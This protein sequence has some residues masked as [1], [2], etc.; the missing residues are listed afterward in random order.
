MGQLVASFVA[1]GS[2]AVSCLC[3]VDHVWG[4]WRREEERT[5]AP[6]P[7]PL[8][9][10]RRHGGGPLPSP[11][12]L[13]APGWGMLACAVLSMCINKPPWPESLAS[14]WALGGPVGALQDRRG[15][16]LAGPHGTGQLE[17]SPNLAAGSGA[18][19]AEPRLQRGRDFGGH[20]EL[21]HT[22]QKGKWR[23]LR[24][25]PIAIWRANEGSQ[26]PL[27]GAFPTAASDL[28]AADFASARAYVPAPPR[29]G[30]S[31][32]DLSHL[33]VY[34]YYELIKTILYWNGRAPEK[35]AS[36]P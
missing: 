28:D 14:P 7:F 21:S 17:G 9:R 15:A 2:G 8:R 23:H 4:P 10:Q 27:L 1:I 11:G 33:C 34:Y 16:C 13:S 19:Q 5:W 32:A 20:L 25:E 12:P 29:Q 24:G 31:F 6:R 18:Q 30:S 36:A 3:G 35:L 26:A 22:S